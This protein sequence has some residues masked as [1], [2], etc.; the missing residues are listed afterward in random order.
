MTT[1]NLVSCVVFLAE[2][3]LVSPF[4]FHVV[5]GYS[6]QLSSLHELARM[7]SGLGQGSPSWAILSLCVLS[8]PYMSCPP[9]VPPESASVV[10]K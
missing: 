7:E 4:Y 5:G 8:P 2:V 6:G 3:A 9:P 10:P 1:V